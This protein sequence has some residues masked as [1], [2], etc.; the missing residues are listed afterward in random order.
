MTRRRHFICKLHLRREKIELKD[1]PEFM[2]RHIA[3]P[4]QVAEIVR[5][6]LGHGA[7]REHF[8]AFH[9]DGKNRIFGFEEVAIGGLDSILVDQASVYRTAFASGARS[10]ILAHNHPSG[11]SLPSPEDRQLT[12]TLMTGAEACGLQILD[13]VV[14]GET[15]CYS[16]KERKQC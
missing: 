1:C 11:D 9:L 7:V 13:H 15:G 5:A 6:V 14:V 3:S 16:F 2:H 10:L 12:K 4:M 8:Y